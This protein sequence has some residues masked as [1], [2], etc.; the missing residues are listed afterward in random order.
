VRV[1]KFR[2]GTGV[3]ETLITS[4]REKRYPFGGFKAL[5]FKRWPVETKYDEVKKK[6]EVENFSEIL[7]DNIRQDFYA[8][9]TL[10]NI[11]VGLYEEAQEEVEEEQRGKGNKWKYQVNVNHEVGVLIEA[12]HANSF[13]PIKSSK[14]HQLGRRE[15]AYN[16]RLSRR[17]VVI[18]HINGKIKTF[19]S[20]VYPYRGHYCNR[21][22]LR[23]T[24]ICGIINYDR[25]V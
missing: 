8:A 5:Y 24:L 16:K 11:A 17:R 7:V 22:S 25:K 9:M 15:K 23:M 3:T 21:H 20:M 1:V 10:T 18:E 13:I 12:Y 19:K 2:L 4:L 14:N 6:L